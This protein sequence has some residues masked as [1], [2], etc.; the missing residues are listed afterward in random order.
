MVGSDTV[1]ILWKRYV[2]DQS[3]EPKQKGGS[4]SKLGEQEIDL[5]KHLKTRTPSLPYASILAVIEQTAVLLSGTSKPA[6][7]Y[8]VSGREQTWYQSYKK[9]DSMCV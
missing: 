7:V 6:A 5:I 9:T 2:K 1:A 4:V 3:L 8:R